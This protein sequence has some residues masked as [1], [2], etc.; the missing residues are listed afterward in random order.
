MRDTKDP[1]AATPKAPENKAAENKAARD[2]RVA[3]A[4]R[5][6]LRRRK[7]QARARAESPDTSGKPD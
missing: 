7:E 5:E 4:L 6:N 2:A 3:A 1:R